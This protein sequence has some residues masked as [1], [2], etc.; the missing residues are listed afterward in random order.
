MFGTTAW[1][2]RTH[3]NKVRLRERTIPLSSAGEAVKHFLQQVRAVRE[4]QILAKKPHR[5]KWFPPAANE[6]KANFDGAWFNES[7]EVGI[8]VVV[9]NSAGQVLAALAEKIK[10]KKPHNVDCLE[11][12]AARNFCTR[13]WPLARGRTYIYIYIYVEILNFGPNSPQLNK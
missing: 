2:I 7:E 8:V 13:N 1:F 6:F 5:N 12:T 10:N 11:M 3:R 4:V 9:R